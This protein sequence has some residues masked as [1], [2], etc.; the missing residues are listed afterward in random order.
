MAGSSLRKADA[1]LARIESANGLDGLADKVAT[2][3]RRLI[4]PG[5]IEDQLSGTAVGHPVHPAIVAVPIGAW[6]LASTLDLTGGDESAADV[7]VAI[8][9]LS[10]LPAALA[11]WSDWLSTEGAERRVGL[12]HGLANFV[13]VSLQSAS[14]VARRRGRRITGAGLSLAALAL[15]GAAGWLGGHLAYAMGVG[16]DT[17]AFQKYPT[18]W[19][20]VLA[21]DDVPASGSA[22]G[23][24]DGVPLLFA[25][26]KGDIVAL[27][28]RCTHRGAPL[29]E[30]EIADGCVTCPWHG[31]VFELSTGDVVSGPATRPQ[32]SLEVRVVDGRV[33][34]RRDEQRTLR[35]NPAGR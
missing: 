12:V 2:N 18:D 22:T 30:G 5:F 24:A 1:A 33:Q 7:A 17:T 25:R 10:A 13:G 6:T 11:G 29:H 16:V 23:E 20:D 19:T 3:M 34:V 31:S 4:R 26:V 21:A 35:T 15:T 9:T 8:G 14:W 32:P 28:D 27:A